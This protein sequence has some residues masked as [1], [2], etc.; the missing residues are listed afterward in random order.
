MVGDYERWVVFWLSYPEHEKISNAKMAICNSSL[1]WCEIYTYMIHGPA[2]CERGRYKY[3][4]TVALK[5]FSQNTP[6]IHSLPHNWSLNWSNVLFNGDQK[7]AVKGVPGHVVTAVS[8][9]WGDWSTA[10]QCA[11]TTRNYKGFGW[12]VGIVSATMVILRTGPVS[13][14]KLS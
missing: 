3:S 12:L 8:E 14:W 2:S 9:K 6:S 5:I 13:V 1:I 11:A 10:W 7:V 4:V